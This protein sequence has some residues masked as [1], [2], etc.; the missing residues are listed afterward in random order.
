MSSLNVRSSQ[1]DLNPPQGAAATVTLQ[2]CG[3]LPWL[4]WIFLFYDTDL[5]RQPLLNS[6]RQTLARCSFR[7]VS[8]I[9]TDRITRTSIPTLT[10]TSTPTT[11]AIQTSTPTAIPTVTLNTSHDPTSGPTSNRVS[12]PARTM[13][14]VPAL[15]QSPPTTPTRI[16]S[17]NCNPQTQSR[18][19]T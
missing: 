15:P 12:I 2:L 3:K 14:P 1:T 19:Q 16:P 4:Q 6:D 11:P 9:V 17:T 7:F 13:I 18:S 10:K 5:Q 8:W